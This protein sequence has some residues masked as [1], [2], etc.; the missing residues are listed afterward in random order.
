MHLQV[1]LVGAEAVGGPMLTKTRQ[2]QNPILFKTGIKIQMQVED[3][4]STTNQ[5]IFK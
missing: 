1:V 3:S 4:I 5:A 2:K